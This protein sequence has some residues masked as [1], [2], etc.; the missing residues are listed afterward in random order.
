MHPVV[1][2]LVLLSVWF[3]DTR[4][5][6][7]APPRSAQ[8]PR[9]VIPTTRVP[10]AGGASRA[11]PWH[12]HIT[13]TIFWI[14]EEPS[15]RNPTPNSKSSWDQAWQE[16]F[17]GFDD[18][19]PE[20]RIASHAR[21]EFRPRDFVPKLNPFY[22]AL[23]YNDV[24]GWG[25]HKPE[26]ARIIPWFASRQPKP[27]ET[28]LKGRWLQIYHQGRSCFAQWEDCGPWVTDD[29]EYVFGNRPPKNR[30]NGGAGIDISPAI[31]DYLGLQSG[32]KC[33]WRF[34]DAAQVPP[35]PWKKYGVAPA[36]R[37]ADGT[38]LEA[39]RRYIQ[40]LRRLRDEHYR[41][42]GSSRSRH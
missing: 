12:R 21:A 8:L 22:V 10:S 1:L 7:Q 26:A 32:E 36:P 16:N 2:F 5:E 11:Y 14:G 9:V 29:W 24:E 18:P 25:R 30:R 42:H 38:D 41:R 35:G 27:G 23:P 15:S 34:V 13:A 20:R 3:A 40:Q 28:V 31:R 19:S 37:A 17:G 39:K 33:H 6:A 4:L